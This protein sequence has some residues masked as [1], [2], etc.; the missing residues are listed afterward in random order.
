M[1][2]KGSNDKDLGNMVTTKDD[3]VRLYPPSDETVG[4]LAS[5]VPTAS[6]DGA[7]GTGLFRLIN[8]LEDRVA[9]LEWYISSRISTVVGSG[10]D[11]DPWRAVDVRANESPPTGRSPMDTPS[12]GEKDSVDYSQPDLPDQPP[13]LPSTT[14]YPAMT[15]YEQVMRDWWEAVRARLSALGA[16]R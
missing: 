10:I 2:R 3:P 15:M 4:G 13:T 9:T 8:D 7:A 11:T 14:P 5:A 16:A 12:Q 6:S 1:G